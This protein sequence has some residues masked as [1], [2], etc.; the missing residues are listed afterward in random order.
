MTD[1]RQRIAGLYR[2]GLLCAGWWIWAFC[3]TAASAATVSS[4]TR[5]DLI[6][7]H[8][9]GLEVILEIPGAAI[10]R[11][12]REMQKGGAIDWSAFGLTTEA[13]LPLL[14]YQ[15][16]LVAAP[17]GSILRLIVMPGEY[18]TLEAVDLLSIDSA[19]DIDRASP[20][21]FLP[22]LYAATDPA[23]V[24]RGVVAHALR[25]YPLQYHPGRRELRVYHQMRVKVE[26][27]GGGTGAGRH[28]TRQPCALH[29][30]FINP[31]QAAAW[32][33]A[34]P[35]ARP[36]VDYWYDRGRPWLRVHVEEDG[37]Y[38]M[39][40]E[41]LSQFMDTAR[42]DPRTFRLFHQGIEQPLYVA[43]EA[44]GTLDHGDYLLFAGRFRR[45]AH[46]FESPYGR[47]DIYWLTWAG[48]GGR[49]YTDVTGA[50]VHG[51]PVQTEFWTT[52]HVQVDSVYDP[53]IG[54]PDIER[55]HWFWHRIDAGS[56]TVPGSGVFP[57]VIHAP[58]LDQ[59]YTARVRV[60]LHGGMPTAH[61]TVVRLAT[62]YTIADSVWGGR[63]VGQV[64]IVFENA[65]PASAL[66]DSINRI[67]VQVYADQEKFAQVYM[68]W[69]EIDYRRRFE[70][71]AGYLAFE[72]PH[73][74]EHRISVSGL[75]HRHVALLDPERGVRLTDMR[76]D[77]TASG[78]RLTFEDRTD[79]SGGTYVLADSMAWLEPAGERAT[80]SDWRLTGHR[81]EY[82][83]IAPPGLLP[84]AERLAAHRRGRGLS[85]AVVSTQD[86]YDEFNYGRVDAGAIADF[87]QYAYARWT[88]PPA[89][90]V[91]FGNDTHDYRDIL[92]YGVPLF[93]PTLYYQSRGRGRAPSDFL[94]SLVD[95]DDLLPDL[96]VGRLLASNPREADVLVDKIIAYDGEPAPG[97]WR[98]RALYLG[99]YHPANEF[100]AFNDTLAAR[101]TEP[102]GLQSVKIRNPDET[103]IP[104]DQS[105]EFMAELERG[106]LLLTFN[107]HGSSGSMWYF[108]SLQFRELDFMGQVNNGPRLP[109]GMA[110]SCLNGMFT[111]P[112]I[113]SIAE[114]FT[115]TPAGGVIAYVTA[116]AQSRPGQNALLGDF[117]FSQFFTESKLQFGPVLDRAKIRTLAANPS[118]DESALT[119][120][121][122]GDPAQ[123]L[124][125]P[126]LPDYEAAALTV[127]PEPLHGE[128]VA[129][130]DV[131]VRNLARSTADSV[132]VLLRA[133]PLSETA[134]A[135]PETLLTRALHGFPGKR[136]LSIDWATGDRR[137][138]YELEFVIDPDAVLRE[139]RTD[140]NRMVARVDILEPLMP[141]LIAPA[142][143]AIIDAAPPLLMAAVPYEGGPYRCDMRVSPYPGLPPEDTMTLSA[144]P[145]EGGLCQ[146]P[147][148]PIDIHVPEHRRPYF[149]QARLRTDA[150]VGS[151]SAAH[152]FRVDPFGDGMTWSQTGLQ[153]HA[154]MND[155]LALIDD[156]MRLTPVTGSLR[157][158]EATREDGFPGSGLTGA[159]VVCTDGVYL[160]VKRWYFDD[161]T[162]YPGTDYFTRIGTG[163]GGTVAGRNYGVLA[164]S[165]SGGIAATYH[166]DGFIYSESGRTY[167]LERIHPQTGV[168]DTVQ[169]PAGLLEIRSGQLR[170]GPSMITSDGRL[171]YNVSMSSDRGRRREWSVRVF[172]PAAGW[173]L[174][175]EFVSPP[176]ESGFTY[177]FTDGILAD[178]ERLYFIEW[179][180]IGDENPRRIRM[181]D[182][183]DGTFLDEWV[184]DQA[185]T[186]VISGQYDWINNKVWLGDLMSP[187]IYRYTGLVY[188]DSASVTSPPI[189]PAAAW[190]A[191]RLYGVM[192]EPGVLPVEVLVETG[193]AWRSFD[194]PYS[195]D[196]EG[197]V[198][199]S[200]LD[201]EQHPRIRLRTLLRREAGPGGFASWAVAFRHRPNLR[202]EAA[203][204]R[205]RAGA[206]QIRAVIRNLSS[207]GV[208]D[209]ELV[210]ER[211]DRSEPLVRMGVG[212]LGVGEMRDVI[213]EQV[214]VPPPDV[215]LYARL[216]SP[217]SGPVRADERVPV[218]L[219][220]DEM[221]ALQLENPLVWP[222]PVRDTAAF[223]YEMSTRA[224]VQVELFTMSGRLIRFLGP[225]TQGPGF[226]QVEWDGRDASGA[227]LANGTYLFR[228][229]ARSGTERVQTRGALVV[230]R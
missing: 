24:L 60:A 81:A 215:R 178:G 47:R 206:L 17:V 130:V 104:N 145:A 14:P 176:T 190:E 38:R 88:E 219:I 68:D 44:T 93:V 30:V 85:T 172:D 110:L 173:S 164:D 87:I 111:H 91:L 147:L 46:D 11:L 77:S 183:Y 161:S 19:A 217:A 83:V 133:W 168:L 62:G 33:Q 55:E 229:S 129:R 124:A 184:S 203:T 82:V 118:F 101:Y 186:G 230:V 79:D 163:Y 36:A 122:F 196:A 194:G 51:Y 54:A 45:G 166:G 21:G 53:L 169:V 201:A 138:E 29:D 92:G 117:M 8:D 70:A 181:V 157:P 212:R 64:G 52:R 174:V 142:A 105:A 25:I 171:I 158:G 225:Y 23:G 58:V 59:D 197:W 16:C 34:R 69:F 227:L 20:E 226:R 187:G 216:T 15:A 67:V 10:D 18:T 75:R 80:P 223:T 121:L 98:S 89:Y 125:L 22:G 143:G 7:A 228:V 179:R 156:T 63:D 199:L 146:W 132:Q 150:A 208:E 148:E 108:F 210:L 126:R 177:E 103:M 32:R 86:I 106:A 207:F 149:W 109:F 160:Y 72:L 192:D 4:Q 114:A 137:G 37:I 57:G 39:D 191:L 195:A 141:V 202:V 13:S 112:G 151:W 41:W 1:L 42:I 165:T 128:T 136:E 144:L 200:A 209:A 116:T 153:W 218:V 94:Y 193:H 31:T 43:G 95:G 222:N 152:T 211:S 205:P 185:A 198:D 65:V 120:Q 84:A 48:P 26:F 74:D 139:E 167:E 49:R 66:R 204:G 170:D 100:A 27:V 12:V 102:Y 134:T 127:S 56:P 5:L 76:L 113:Q 175:R 71:R 96:S 214:D 188:V 123:S 90:V 73:S 220:T 97:D 159:G 9:H 6:D 61:N 155:S 224:E 107:G 189:G 213:V 50:P 131:T 162:I 35:R 135:V 180:R 99:G 154:S 78:M 182:A 115:T 221:A 2:L 40:R 140:N 28:S 119:M 3:M